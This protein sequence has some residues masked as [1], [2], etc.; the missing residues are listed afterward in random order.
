MNNTG[1]F[2]NMEIIN[3][4]DTITSLAN[5]RLNNPFYSFNNSKGT[6]VTYYNTD[7][8][9]MPLDN[10]TGL[11][12]R[13]K[14]KYSNCKYNK[15]SKFVL[16]GL[17]R[18]PV[19][20]EDT[21]EGQ[22]AQE[23]SGEA[24][25]LPNTIT[26]YPG[27][28]FVIDH[29]KDKILFK[30]IDA[31]SDTFN[32]GANVWQIQYKLDDVSNK[33]LETYNIG[34]KYIFLL[35]NNG[36]S[37]NSIIEENEFNIIR[38][39][40]E[41]S[42]NMREYYKSIFYNDRVQSLIV[43]ANNNKFYDSFLTEFIIKNKLLED[44]NNYLYLAHQLSTPKTFSL[45]Y[46][47]SFF[48]CIEEKNIDKLKRIDTVAYGE[49]IDNKTSIFSTRYEPY[50]KMTYIKGKISDTFAKGLIFEIF[51]EDL[52]YHIQNNKLYGNDILADIIIKY[53]NDENIT[54]EDYEKL[55]IINYSD[56][57]VLF[58]Y[59]PIAIYILE[60]Y[61]KKLMSNKVN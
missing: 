57:I 33:E 9:N 23:I 17:D 52:I 46:S 14:G 25:I 7:I 19:T 34:K 2:T 8:N 58:Y 53:F 55:D 16:Y 20:L 10:V 28:F 3:N 60:Y 42:D 4:I 36:T 45:D 21:E 27:D 37:Y 31:Q 47:R 6:V 40:E 15:I 13:H 48:Y 35:N 56:N 61:I 18:M 50:L 43:S 38:N 5:D 22:Q 59:V 39:L 51:D 54:E 41:L 49:L 30:V 32:N 12:Y 29:I 44:K 24:I 26:P 1:K 11:E